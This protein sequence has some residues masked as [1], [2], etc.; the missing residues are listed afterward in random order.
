MRKERTRRESCSS[1]NCLVPNICPLHNYTIPS[2]PD[3]EKPQKP[4]YANYS[5]RAGGGEGGGVTLRAQQ[6]RTSCKLPQTR[7][8][9][10]KRQIG[11]EPQGPLPKSEGPDS[12]FPRNCSPKGFPLNQEQVPQFCFSSLCTHFPSLEFPHP[13]RSFRTLPFPEASTAAR[14]RPRS[15]ADFPTCPANAQGA[16]CS[17]LFC[18]VLLQQPKMSLKIESFLRKN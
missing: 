11:S 13:L 6:P 16:F 7:A 4:H 5:K 9:T 3:L 18:F 17:V 15:H 8:L 14:K 12:K 1:Q 2:P 10:L